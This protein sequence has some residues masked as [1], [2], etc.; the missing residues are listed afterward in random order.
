MSKIEKFFD[1][2]L[3]PKNIKCVICGDELDSD[4]KY[5]ICDKC[6]DELPFID[7]KTCMRCGCKITDMGKVCINCKQNAHKFTA[8]YSVFEYVEPISTKV[9]QLK[10]SNRKYLAYTFANFIA[11]KAIECGKKF[12]VVLP[13]PLAPK[14]LKARGYNQSELLCSTLKELGYNVKTDVLIKKVDT[15]TQV[16]LEREE[17]V[18]N[19]EGVFKVANR[20]AVKGKV[21]LLVDDVITTGTTLDEC[22]DVL[23]SAG[24][25]KVY[26]I[27]LC[28]A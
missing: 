24:A 27:T 21:V 26:C 25:T 18:K 10:F 12:D 23:K 7:G 16:G 19:L 5:C 17:R 2:I 8:N 3:F 9:R 4:K 15:H 11:T 28:H 1:T 6:F 13:V 20:K 22:A 14:A